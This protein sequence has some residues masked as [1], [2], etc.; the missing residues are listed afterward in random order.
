MHGVSASGAAATP[1]PT[2]DPHAACRP[3]GAGCHGLWLSPAEGTRSAWLTS[4][5]SRSVQARR[6]GRPGLV[7]KAV[8]LEEALPH[9]GPFAGAH[10]RQRCLGH[11]DAL[12]GVL[13]HLDD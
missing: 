2:D 5:A 9:L 12:R 10:N 1:L 4:D 11:L 8:R 13:Q 7:P 6:T 3:G